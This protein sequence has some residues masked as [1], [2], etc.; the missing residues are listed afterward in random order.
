MRPAALTTL[1][2]L[3]A[4]SGRAQPMAGSPRDVELLERALDGAV[5]Q[6]SRA[7]VAHPLG[8]GEACHSYALKGYGVVFVLAPRVL[9]VP[10]SLVFQ[11]EGAGADAAALAAGIR[12]MEE[13]LK[14]VSS[15]EVRAQMR[16]RM[17]ALR[18]MQQAAGPSARGARSETPEEKQIRAI[19]Q[20][21]VAMEQEADQSRREAERALDAF[22]REVQTRL[23]PSPGT[24]PPAPDPVVAPAVPAVPEAAL[25]P[26][27]VLPPPPPWRSWF[28][29]DDEPAG[30]APEAVIRD[31]R[32][33]VTNTLESQGGRVRGVASDEFVVVA[34]DFVARG[35]FAGWG[36]PV[37]TLVVKVRKKELEERLAGRL[38]SE[39][40]RKRIE[41]LEY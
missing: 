9:P 39:E 18:R 28:D 3:L 10:R 29:S 32:T 5:R 1:F 22:R 16:R 34:V 25:E 7:S 20:Q 19:E 26:E 23:G 8:V 41:Y 38:A 36:R 2:I 11:G 21:A 27:D 37:R 35:S 14:R 30:R 31:V 33:A 4:A 40:L 12:A 17:D 24:P 13:G 15:P 6:V